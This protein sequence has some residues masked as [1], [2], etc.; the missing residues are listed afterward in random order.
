MDTST[1]IGLISLFA[2]L[3][4]FFTLY[5]I[6]A[7][8]VYKEAKNGNIEEEV[9]G[10]QEETYEADDSLG[11][12][13]R[14][15]LNNFMPQL[16]NIPM[17]AERKKKLANL[18]IKSGNPWKVSPEE[19]IGL[20]IAL[21]VLGL[22]AGSALAVANIVPAIIP[23]IVLVFF[24]GAVGY[25]VPFSIYNSRKQ[26]RSKAVE[27]ELPGALDLLTI[28]IASGQ[29][30]EYALESVTKQLPEGLLRVEFAK[31]I[32]ELQA[33]SSLE[34]SFS[35]LSH[36][37]ESEDLESFTKAVTQS[38]HLGSDVSET[39]AQQADFVRSNYEAR[40]EKMIAKLE[41]TMFIPLIVTMLPAFM[42]IFIA[43][44]ISQLS[45]F[46]I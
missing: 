23:P 8:V 30:F 41:T 22:L 33:G 34:R 4:V 15:V 37:F 2:A 40:L 6:Y 13:V 5:A 43:P 28:T 45:G 46:M 24:F 11:K 25:L 19:F 7:P 42:I 32:V 36:K 38:S 17:D 18:I 21:G 3:T 20:Q 16:P 1:S 44:T 35:D 12:Y 14:P 26:A 31:V 10:L 27:K 39:L 29:V 9:F